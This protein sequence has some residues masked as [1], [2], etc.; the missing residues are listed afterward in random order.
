MGELQGRDE[1]AAVARVSIDGS[2]V[3]VGGAGGSVHV[4]DVGSGRPAGAPLAT[5][6][7]FAFGFVD[8][9]D[10]TRVF[11]VTAVGRDGSVVLW[12]VSAPDQPRR[13]GPPYRFEV[14]R[15]AVPV[16]AI[17]SDGQLLA[18]GS[19]LRGTVGTTAVFDVQSHALLHELDEPPG[20]FAPGTHTLTTAGAEQV[21][22]WDAATGLP[23]G[24]P[25]TGFGRDATT[26]QVFSPDGARLAVL[27]RNGGIRVFDLASREQVGSPLGLDPGDIP[28]GFLADG[29]LVTS[30]GTAIAI[31]R[32]GITAP[33][34]AVELDAYPT[35]ETIAGEFVPGSDDVITQTW[36]EGSSFELLRWTASTG[37]S[38]GPSGRWRSAH[39]L[40]G[41]PRR[42]TPRRTGMV[43]FW[44]RRVEPRHERARRRVR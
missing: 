26:E 3:A 17:S 29:R 35:P 37:E 32:A 23:G 30:G 1:A 44:P 2:R 39:V 14:Q 20:A 18:A 31:W 8:P 24:E 36:G 10:P 7:D 12:D 9:T 27:E 15:G 11:T 33:P 43:R 40:L 6:G 38:Q 4:W 13:I 42:S 22:F 21:T 16:A 34:F 41:Q 19:S 5:G 28:V 25:L